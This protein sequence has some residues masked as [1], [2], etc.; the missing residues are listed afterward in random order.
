MV[1]RFRRRLADWGLRLV[2]YSDELSVESV[3][4]NGDRRLEV[5]N[6]SIDG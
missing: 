5:E 3:S 4:Q 6:V 2:K 1:R